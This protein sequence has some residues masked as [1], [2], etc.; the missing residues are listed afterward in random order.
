M[1]NC[2]FNFLYN[3]DEKFRMKKPKY[4]ETN[5]KKSKTK[6]KAFGIWFKYFHS[7]CDLIEILKSYTGI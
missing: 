5:C 4:L 2:E 3:R 6:N 7:I 1:L